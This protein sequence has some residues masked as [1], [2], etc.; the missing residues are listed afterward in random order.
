MIKRV[1]VQYEESSG[2]IF[3]RNGTLIT[4]W[5]GLEHMGEPENGSNVRDLIK[6]KEAGFTAED[7]VAMKEGGVL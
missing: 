4:A 6:L 5:H 7:I 2:N 1:I 3:D